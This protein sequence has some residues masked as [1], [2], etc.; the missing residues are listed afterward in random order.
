MDYHKKY[1]EYI[2]SERYKTYINL[3]ADDIQENIKSINKAQIN[4]CLK[5]IFWK[6]EFVING[7]P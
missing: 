3:V 4:E 6:K 2:H 5:K 1:R 7:L